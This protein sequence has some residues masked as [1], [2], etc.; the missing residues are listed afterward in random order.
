MKYRK[1]FVMEERK[2]TTRKKT[3]EQCI[4][5]FI[6]V[7]GDRYDYRFVQYVNSK[8]NVKIICKIHGE[9]EQTPNSHLGGKNCPQ[10]A[11]AITKKLDQDS[12]IKRFK[13]IH[14]DKYDYSFVEYKGMNEPIDVYCPRHEHHFFPRP[15]NHINNRT[16]CDKCAL[17]R[18]AN[19]SSM[20][21]EEFIKKATT[22]HGDKYDYSNVEYVN[23]FTKV[24]I[25]CKKHNTIFQQIPN[26]HLNGR[27][28]PECGVEYSNGF[29]KC[30]KELLKGINIPCKENDRTLIPPLEIDMYFPDKKLGI[31][32]DGVYWHGEQCKGETAKA[33]HLM[34][35]KQCL[36]KGV[37]LMHFYDVEIDSKKEL[38]L[39][40]IH[41]KL[42][43][44][45]NKIFARKC[46]VKELNYKS[47]KE[48][49]D[50]N[51]LQ[52]GGAVGS[53][54][55]GLYYNDEL[56]SVMT[57]GKPR[58]N[59]NYDYELIRFCNKINTR[60]VGAASKLFQHALKQGLNNIISYANRRWSNGDLYEK[61]G[62]TKTSETEPNYFYT[63]GYKMYSRVACQKHKLK[64]VLG[65]RFDEQLSEHENMIA[66]NYYRV[67]DCGNLV[68][69]Y[70]Q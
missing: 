60:V 44:I 9:F 13:E 61:L 18:V 30:E 20:G 27:G 31:E 55:Y 68:F 70:K 48:F 58:F 67:Y 14:G 23:A 45:E 8:T 33:Y 12:V 1:G 35:S 22:I 41:S 39:S 17:E 63:N 6:S 32:V 56:V 66:A 3:T 49:L 43:L 37:L 4:S 36:E 51:H 65:E 40:M 50:T 15:A 47:T 21:K 42:G 11:K 46:V 52:G 5:D 59:K 24:D 53:E 28:C 54:R 10:C 16:G 19:N 38:I 7:H 69:E 34:K 25:L 57:F 26:S 62:F 29:S 64:D 2:K